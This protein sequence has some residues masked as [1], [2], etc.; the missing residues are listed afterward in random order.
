[1]YSKDIEEVI[2]AALLVGVMTDNVRNA[3]RSKAE[4]EGEDADEVIMVAEMRLNKSLQNTQ[5]D[6]EYGIIT[7]EHGAKEV[8]D[9][10]FEELEKYKGFGYKVYEAIDYNCG[11]VATFVHD[12][13]LYAGQWGYLEIIWSEL[14]PNQ[15]ILYVKYEPMSYDDY[16]N[17]VG[18]S[19]DM[20][21]YGYRN[22][23][24]EALANA[25]DRICYTFE[26]KRGKA[27]I[28]QKPTKTEVTSPQLEL[29]TI[30]KTTQL[31]VPKSAIQNVRK[32]IEGYNRKAAKWGYELLTFNTGSNTITG[33]FV[34]K[35]DSGGFMSGFKEGWRN[36]ELEEEWNK[37]LKL[38]VWR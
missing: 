26:Y 24:M 4:E 16:M 8:T 38:C 10:Q 29:K 28:I 22:G 18:E 32:L 3:L 35:N 34:P 1:M 19:F 15:H 9:K 12:Y 6:S 11:E 33:K 21:D 30:G 13:N 36:G 20:V 31:T 23:Y 27:Q 17:I 14:F 2:D 37:I 25:I 5:S 7:W